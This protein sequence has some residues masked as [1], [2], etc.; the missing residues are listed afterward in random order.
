[1]RDET[2][3]RTR[4]LLDAATAARSRDDFREAER[5]ALEAVAAAA[6]AGDER[7][8]AVAVAKA[9]SA[10]YRQGRLAEAEAL[11]R[12]ALDIDAE[13][14][15]TLSNLALVVATR[16]RPAEALDLYDEAL[17]LLAAGN[18]R[19]RAITLTNMG[20]L[21]ERLEL[22][23]EA[24]SAFEL[25][26]STLEGAVGDEVWRTLMN[27]ANNQGVVLRKLGRLEEAAVCYRRTRE[28]AAAHDDRRGEAS[29]EHNLALVAALHGDLPAAKV[30][31]GRALELRRAY[32][33][34]AEQAD[35]LHGLGRVHMRAGEPAHACVQ[36]EAAIALRRAAGD[37]ADVIKGALSL[38]RARIA[39]GRRH[40]ARVVLEEGRELLEQTRAAIPAG[41]LRRAFVGVAGEL[42]SELA[43]LVA[44]E[45]LAG[46][47]ALA[48]AGRARTLQERLQSGPP[49]SSQALAQRRR[50]LRDELAALRDAPQSPARSARLVDLRRELRRTAASDQA[51]TRRAAPA[52]S[53]SE[54]AALLAPG[55]TMLSFVVGRERS[56]V[57]MLQGGGPPRVRQLPG[58][59]ALAA[60]AGDFRS[61]LL[62]GGYDRE[63]GTWLRD[64][65]LVGLPD[66]T[67]ELVVVADGP[68]HDLPWAALPGNAA[69][70]LVADHALRVAPSGAVY[71]WPRPL[72]SHAVTLI[73]LAAPADMET[74]APSPNG[75]SRARAALRPIPH[76]VEEIEAI[77]TLMAGDGTVITRAREGAT[78]AEL[79]LLLRRH[80]PPRYLHLACHGILY[81]D[82]PSLSGVA[83]T[84]PDGQGVE[85]WR[86]PQIAAAAL[87]C[88]LVVLSACGSAA[89]P[90]VPGEG[91]V[92]L[93]NALL[94]AGASNVC[95][96]LWDV[97]DRAAQQLMQRFYGRLRAGLG[98]AEALAAAQGEMLETEFWHPIDWAWAVLA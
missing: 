45:D 87:D 12:T 92:S 26:E 53:L 59:E 63:S 41:E 7:A 62:E 55:R 96:A 1:M 10:M 43:I 20:M 4:E 5:L 46:A 52:R 88:E 83:L 84:S 91:V 2:T 25:A 18:P 14:G 11:L 76:S 65:L 37:P 36:F 77:A 34:P 79:E 38:G 94:S 48:E 15:R 40:A 68:L 69:E 32:G 82:E 70:Y 54:L 78:R 75:V 80:G 30:G 58:H 21:F 23:P 93:G 60:K 64:M 47:F 85:I 29:A 72:R 44:D 39:A 66:D 17:T 3:G 50:Q 90:S 57:V 71:A 9:S 61:A 22:L 81:Q 13:R 42:Y 28:L 33:D 35:A 95:V 6:A 97:D 74:G 51:P 8:R 49:V 19:H 86:A 73:A 27:V 16:G 56:L 98:H 67:R 24:M 31:Y 89:G